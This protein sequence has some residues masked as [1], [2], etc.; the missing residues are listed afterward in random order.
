SAPTSGA[1]AQ[2]PFQSMLIPEPERLAT[3]MTGLVGT[4]TPMRFAL[5]TSPT[6]RPKRPPCTQPGRQSSLELGMNRCPG[7][8]TAYQEHRHEHDEAHSGADPVTAA[9]SVLSEDE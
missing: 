2:Q 1:R 6:W 8:E 9:P 3:A 4:P 5:D 7:H